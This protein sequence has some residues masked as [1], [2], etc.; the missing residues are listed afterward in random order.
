MI[1]SRVFNVYPGM[2]RKHLESG[3]GCTWCDGER[4]EEEE[5]EVVC[6]EVCVFDKYKCDAVSCVHDGRPQPTH[7]RPS[8]VRL[9]LANIANPIQFLFPDTESGQNLGFSI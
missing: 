2:K 3:G 1:S 8:K 6:L 7:T 4:E 9:W 5:E